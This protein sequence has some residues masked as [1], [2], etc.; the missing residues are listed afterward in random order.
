MPTFTISEVSKKTG[1]SY[2]TIRYY[3]KIGLISRTKRKDN[4]QLEFDGHALER[5]IFINCLKR[6][7][8]PLKEIQR[9]M[10]LVDEQNLESCYV[11]LEDHKQNI[12]SQIEERHETLRKIQFKLDNFNRLKNN[13]DLDELVRLNKSIDV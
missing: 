13:R 12:E 9:Y 2:D 3:E 4:G 5:L 1:F 6:T 11:M 8:M 10:N 7:E